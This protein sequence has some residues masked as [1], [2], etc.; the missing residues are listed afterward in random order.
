MIYDLAMPSRGPIGAGT[1]PTQAIARVAAPAPS[2][3]CPEIRLYQAPD[4][5]A[6]W[7]G[8]AAP[9]P[10]LGPACPYWACPWPG[11]EAL[12][13]YLLDAPER[14]RGRTVY[15]LG[16]GGGIGAIAAGQAGARRVHAV[17][18]DPFA[19]A[20][21]ALNARLTAIAIDAALDDPLDRAPPSD[22]D[23]ILAADLWFEAWLARRV[24]DWLRRA[25]RNGV[26]VLAADLGRAHVP[27]GGRTELA[28]Y[29]VPTSP[30]SERQA[31]T[32][33]RVFELEGE[34]AR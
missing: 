12:A 16:A 33:T 14:V 6:A 13:R 21:I 3:L 19:V 17:D 15:E 8:A 4:A 2:V 7:Q 5:L 34:P 18:C 22:V 24:T 1:D 31:L 28:S 20:A 25:S 9:L 11:G 27:R 23:V 10:D 32:T 30:I 26:R 29:A